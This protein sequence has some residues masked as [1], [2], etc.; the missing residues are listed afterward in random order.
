M[1]SSQLPAAIPPRK[2]KQIVCL[3]FVCL[4]QNYPTRL[5]PQNVLAN[6]AILAIAIDRWQVTNRLLRIGKESLL[7][8]MH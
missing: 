7:I 5:P 6:S 8:S 3:K 1:R 4:G 2:S